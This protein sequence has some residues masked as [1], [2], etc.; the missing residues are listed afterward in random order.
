MQIKTQ[1]P[2]DLLLFIISKLDPFREAIQRPHRV[3][4]GVGNVDLRQDKDAAK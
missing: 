1:R 3:T 4:W 2:R